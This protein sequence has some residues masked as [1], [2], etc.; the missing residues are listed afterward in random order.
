MALVRTFIAIELSAE[1]LQALERIADELRRGPGGEAGRWVRAESIHLTLKFL[2]EI[3]SARLPSVFHAVREASAPLAPLALRLAGLGCF[4]NPHRPRVVW[5]GVQEPTGQLGALQGAIEAALARAGFPREER[6]F[7]PHLTLAR[8]HERAA[9]PEIEA[10]GAAVAAYRLSV[11]PAM[12]AREVHVIQSDL[13]P[14]GPI[15]T[16]LDAAP[17]AGTARPARD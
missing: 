15:Y 12:T 8:I 1:I 4:P 6:G 5:A 2:G 11:A 13:R 9:R 17:L 14:S 10:L 16:S 7:T 3:E